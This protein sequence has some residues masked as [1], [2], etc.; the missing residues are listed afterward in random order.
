VD[1]ASSRWDQ[2]QGHIAISAG[3]GQVL[4]ALGYN[5]P[6]SVEE[7]SWRPGYPGWSYVSQR[8]FTVGDVNQEQLPRCAFRAVIDCG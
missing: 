2:R 6:V 4:T 5:Q 8:G 7:V 3:N 1:S